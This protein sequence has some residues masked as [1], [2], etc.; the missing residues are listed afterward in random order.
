MLKSIVIVTIAVLNLEPVETAYQEEF[1]YTTV[2]QS[3]VSQELA[4][5]WAAPQMQGREYLLMKADSEADVFLRFV[6]LPGVQ[7]YK[8]M[9]THGWNATELL[10]KDPDKVA[11]QLEDSAFKIIGAPKD[12]W[13]APNAPRAMQVLGPGEEVMYLTRNVD[14]ST[15]AAVDRV[16]I[17]VLAGPSMASLAS[18]YGDTLGLEV[19]AATPFNISVVSN[20]QGLP[21][22]DSYPSAHAE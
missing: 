5:V 13:Q 8:A 14:F 15:S 9:T 4:G 12:L 22:A 19:S 1:G 16:F 10:V 18:F 17:M 3:T 2:E 20:A 6:Q 11:A 7:G 21:A